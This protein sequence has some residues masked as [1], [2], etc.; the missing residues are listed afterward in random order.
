[1]GWICFSKHLFRCRCAL[2]WLVLASSCFFL[3]CRPAPARPP[4]PVHPSEPI[5]SYLE[6][7]PLQLTFHPVGR[8]PIPFL[9]PSALSLTPPSARFTLAEDATDSLTNLALAPDDVENGWAW[10]LDVFQHLPEC[11]RAVFIDQVAMLTPLSMWSRLDPVLDQPNWGA[12][13]QD[14]LFHRLLE[15]PLSMQLPRLVR[16]AMNPCHPSSSKAN[17]LLQS[18]FPD[19]RPQDYPA[20]LGRISQP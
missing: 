1:M 19:I 10:V 15:L 5:S 13:V 2:W 14:R 20:Y 4:A 11:D 17:A 8:L 16:L 18:Y 6:P 7:S 3:A 9:E 12:E